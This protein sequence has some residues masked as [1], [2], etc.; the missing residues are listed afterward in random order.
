M[1]KCNIS[2]LFVFICSMS[3][4]GASYSQTLE[5]YGLAHVTTDYV[6]IDIDSDSSFNSNSSRIGLRGNYE[7][8]S[9]LSII[10]QYE[11]GLDL[12]FRGKNDDGNGGN[13]DGGRVFSKTRPSFI[14]LKSNYGTIKYGH[15][16]AL[17]QWANEY[18]LF[19]DR[20]GDLGN[21]WADSG[22]PGRL[23]DVIQYETPDTLPGFVS[24]SYRP[25]DESQDILIA[26][27]GYRWQNM[28][29]SLTHASVEQ[30]IL[31]STDHVAKAA[32]FTYKG[33]H[34]SLGFGAQRE[35][36]INGVPGT[37]RDSLM[38]GGSIDLNEQAC[39]KF[40]IANSSGQQPDSDGLIW[41]ASYDYLYDENITIYAAYARVANDTNVNFSVSGKGHGGGIKPPLGNNSY[42]FSLGLVATFE[43][44][45]FGQP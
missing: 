10:Y 24:V 28:S 21:L 42:A 29:L 8:S 18:N 38:L 32:V 4:S 12:T 26:R 27:G 19:A 7:L 3:L 41:A 44:S 40:H 9:S 1:P 15:Q 34:Y 31:Q 39:V 11:S 5:V 16:A 6:D 20:V 23:D 17:D 35:T 45:L 2:S 33:E 43:R 14:G 25:K 36:D 13:N 37:S 30:G 22:L